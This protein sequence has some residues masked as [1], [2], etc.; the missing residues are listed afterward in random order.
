MMA[1]PQDAVD[2]KWVTLSRYS[3]IQQSGIDVA[4]KSLSKLI[5]VD[6]KVLK[7][8]VYLP[9]TLD[10]NSVY[11]FECHEYVKVPKDHVA[12]LIVRSSYNRQGAFITTGLYDN[13]FKNYIGGILR[14]SLPLWLERN[15]RIAQI[16]FMRSNAVAQYNGKYQDGKG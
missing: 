14:T 13:G 9:Q 5:W 16:V 3:K 6:G 10:S 1:R 15:E 7:V 8:P 4:I 11:D 2:K 12:L